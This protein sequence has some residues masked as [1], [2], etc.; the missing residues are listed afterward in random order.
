MTKT[1]HLVVSESTKLQIEI[2]AEQL[3]DITRQLKYNAFFAEHEKIKIDGKSSKQ[4]MRLMNAL[5]DKK[6]IKEAK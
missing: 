4:I 1:N 3:V 5:L 6:N 2:T